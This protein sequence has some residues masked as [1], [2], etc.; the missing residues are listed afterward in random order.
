[1][2]RMVDRLLGDAA[3]T[4]SRHGMTKIT[5]APTST[6]VNH[7]I[8]LSSAVSALLCLLVPGPDRLLDLAPQRL[9]LPDTF[10]LLR[11]H[12]AKQIAGKSIPSAGE[13]ATWSQAGQLSRSPSA[14]PPRDPETDLPPH[15]RTRT[16][17]RTGRTL[18]T[19]EPRNVPGKAM[20]SAARSSPERS[21][22]QWRIASWKIWRRMSA[23]SC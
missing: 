1:M 10:T 14:Q 16:G 15:T 21:E 3:Q 5:N 23:S 6:S 22:G 18:P 8:A 20:R 12:V 11:S 9:F 17:P 19:R 7:N 4:S 2:L 13:T